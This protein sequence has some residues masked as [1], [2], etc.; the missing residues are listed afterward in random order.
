VLETDDPALRKYADDRYRIPLPQL[1]TYAARRPNGRLRY[2]LDGVV[3]DAPRIGSDPVLSR[4]VP[5][6]RAKVQLFR[7]VDMEDP[8]RC[9]DRWGAAR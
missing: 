6:W 9:Q 2:A 3:R 1:Q 5:A 4:R 8:P 7:A